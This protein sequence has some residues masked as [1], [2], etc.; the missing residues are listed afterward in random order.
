M[1]LVSA[2]VRRKKSKIVFRLVVGVLVLLL[3]A[4]LG[5]DYWFYRA[6]KASLPQRDGT[7]RL[8]GLTAPVIV[9]YDSLGVPNI[10]A[11]NLPDLLFAQGYIT[12]QDRLWQ[13]DMTRRFASGDLAVMLGPKY[14]K[15]DRE[16]RILGCGK[17]PSER[18]PAWIRQ[19]AGALRGLCRRA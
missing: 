7:M 10:A 12:A 8:A 2:P 5:F 11:S 18:R 3:L 17:L 4:F 13:M 19:R 14:V 16:Q 15:Y 9:T 1:A 6:V